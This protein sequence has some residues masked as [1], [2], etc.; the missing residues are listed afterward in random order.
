[1][2]AH[3]SMTEAPGRP[4]RPIAEGLFEQD[5]DTGVWRLLGSRCCRC[6]EVVFPAMRDCPNCVGHDTMRPCRLDG[7]G[8]IRDFVVVHRGA[9]G[10]PVPYVQ[11]FIKLDDGPV[12]YSNIDGVDP[13]GTDI[14]IGMAVEMRI[15]VVKTVDGID[16]IGWTFH[17]VGARR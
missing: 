15:G 4:S 6:D 14:H 7:R 16:H 5:G 12:I 1:M 11:S 3:V 10:F 8:V 9:E 2:A 13:E 17:P